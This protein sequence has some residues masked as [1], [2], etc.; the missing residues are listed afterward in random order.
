M[1]SR[2][3]DN[4]ILSEEERLKNG[5]AQIMRMVNVKVDDDSV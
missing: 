5:S 4:S 3:I 2:W 1:T